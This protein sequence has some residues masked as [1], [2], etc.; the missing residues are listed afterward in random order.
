MPP[1]VTRT[2]DRV[3][4]PD[5]RPLSEQPDVPSG[6][7]HV[8]DAMVQRLAQQSDTVDRIDSKASIL[9]G[10]LAV[11]LVGVTSVPSSVFGIRFS[12]LT[13]VILLGIAIACGLAAL[14]PRGWHFRPDPDEYIR[15]RSWTREQAQ[16][17]DME[18][19]Y[20]SVVVNDE[21]LEIKVWWFNAC[22]LLVALSVAVFVISASLQMARTQL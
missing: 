15:Y 21:L 11:F 22:L 2:Y 14:K 7:D 8:Y 1:Q 20:A 5:P 13:V 9:I 12:R 10:F 4:M 18:E 3:E 17:D 6:A 19:A 16:A